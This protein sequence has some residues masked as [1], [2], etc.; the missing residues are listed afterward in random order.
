MRL[1]FELVHLQARLPRRRRHVRLRILSACDRALS[2]ILLLLGIYLTPPTLQDLYNNITALYPHAQI[3][4]AG[5]SLGGS[6]ASLLSLTY[7]VPSISF[8]APGEMMPAQRL[9][10]PLPPGLS[11]SDSIVTTHV[12][13]TADPIAMGVCVQAFFSFTSLSNKL[14]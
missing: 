4:L 5:H 7:G 13:H 10:L 11:Y 3:W 1:L 8:E 6:L 2:R 9:H 12:Y 14:A